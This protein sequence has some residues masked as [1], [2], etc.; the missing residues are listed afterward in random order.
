MSIFSAIGDFFTNA[1]T[2]N[3]SQHQ[4]D[5]GKEQL[6]KDIAAASRGLAPAVVVE[7][8]KQAV[9]EYE[10]FIRSIDAHPDDAS[11]RLPILG[12]VGSPEFLAN[13]DK[14]IKAIWVLVFLAVAVYFLIQMGG[15][16]GVKK[17]VK[18]VRG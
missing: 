15:I 7:K 12:K 1:A 6:A 4:V 10:S 13:L 3:L 11:L 5:A 14:G 2:G 9:A 16:A 18:K 8:Q 17:A